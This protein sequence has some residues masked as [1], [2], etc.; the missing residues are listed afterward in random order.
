MIK[1]QTQGLKSVAV[2]GCKTKGKDP[3][4]CVLAF[5]QRHIRVQWQLRESET[6]TDALSMWLLLEYILQVS[7]DSHWAGR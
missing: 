1:K 4:F 2:K 5:F 6:R 7:G 3:D